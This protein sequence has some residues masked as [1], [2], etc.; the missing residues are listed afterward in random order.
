RNKIKNFFKSQDKEFSLSKGREM[1]QTELEKQG[2]VPNQFLDKKSIDAVL[3]KVNFRDADALFAAIGFGEA[4]AATI[5]NRLTE[6]ARKELEKTKQNA[7]AKA[8][9]EGEVKREKKEIKKTSS[10]E[11]V[12][13]TGA[14]G[15]LVRISKC[16]NPVP[17]DEIVGYITKG[18]GV[19]IH[20]T[21]CE[22]LKH[23]EDYEHRLVDVAWEMSAGAKDY[24]ADIDVYSFNRPGV[25]NDVMQVLSN[26]TKN[27]ISIN[28]QPTKDRKMATIHISLGIKNLSDLTAIVDKI[29]MT[30][31]VYS[32]KRTNG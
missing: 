20:R 6:K 13:V 29:K 4:R 28:A 1:L 8:L 14:D 2:F 11:G 15:L 26:T 32:V 17:G 10:S 16:C 24:V 5:A 27:L 9:L 3:K 12:S 23:Q 19:S 25:L 30:P 22:N 31:D 18:R 7:E 21:D